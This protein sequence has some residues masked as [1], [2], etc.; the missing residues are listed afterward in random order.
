MIG[1]VDVAMA[2]LVIHE[3]GPYE[4]RGVDDDLERDLAEVVQCFSELAGRL[5]PSGNVIV[6]CDERAERL[7]VYGVPAGD[8]DGGCLCPLLNVH[9]EMRLRVHDD[10]SASLVSIAYI[11]DVLE[12]GPDG[13][14]REALQLLSSHNGQWAAFS[15]GNCNMSERLDLYHTAI[16]LLDDLRDERWVGPNGWVGALSEA[17]HNYRDIHNE[18]LWGPLMDVF[19]PIE[20]QA[21]AIATSTDDSRA[22]R[23]RVCELIAH[24]GRDFGWIPAVIGLDDGEG[25]TFRLLDELRE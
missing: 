14:L 6:V 19:D 4:H 20:N 16:N 2:A 23:A 1:D 21:R 22:V 9:S 15:P 12:A 25:E 17:E 18:R 3:P 10:G 24:R 5:F 13:L 7:C 11:G 8:D